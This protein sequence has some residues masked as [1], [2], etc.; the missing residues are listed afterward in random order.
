MKAT[1]NIRLKAEVL[2]TQGRAVQHSMETL[3]IDGVQKVR[4]G[5]LVEIDFEAKT[6]EDEARRALARACEELLANPV[7]E[8]FEFE[9]H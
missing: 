3:G 9:I 4:I 5:R 7:I 2:D 6:S 1:V 8:D